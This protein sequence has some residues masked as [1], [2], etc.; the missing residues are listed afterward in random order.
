M[1]QQ[2]ATMRTPAAYDGVTRYAHKHSGEAAAA[3]Y[4]A[5]GHA[6]L[7]DKRYAEAEASLRQ[8]RQAGDVL[9]DYA[10]FLGAQASHEAG[11]DSAAEA[12][13][14]GFTGRYPDS[15]F[16]DEAPE[17]EATVLLAMG[18]AP[19]AQKVLAQAAG[20]AA[21]GRPGFLLAQG[22]VEFSLGQEQ[23]AERTFKRL[24]LGHPLSPEAETARARLTA[25]GAETSLTTAELRILGDAYYNGGHYAEAAE[26]Y[27]A[28]AREAG[29]D[30]Q[31]RNG[32]AVAEAA[33]D[34]K[35]KRLT[36]T[37]A[38]ALADTQD[39]NGARRLYLL[40]ELARN[41]DDEKEQKRI[42]AEMESSFPNSPW[43]VEALYSSG[44]MYLLRKRLCHGRR[45]LQLS[46]HALS[47]LQV[48]RGGALAGRL[49]QLPAGPLRRCGTHL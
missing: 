32:F 27:R 49:A 38:E 6:Y 41:R 4:L 46:G 16:A 3:A 21:A 20:L 29:L 10:D 12:L 43:L 7:V 28:L 44:N 22:Q 42:V 9:A 33:C 14:R 40:M 39:E 5:L 17:L 15:I 23:A 47:R 45:V 19:G 36:T 13:L 31:T 48:R 2:L 35:L 1:A 18:N 25:M 24:L 30:A 37:Q 26:Q 8:A 34:L 11:N